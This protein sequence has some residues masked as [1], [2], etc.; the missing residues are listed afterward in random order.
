MAREAEAAMDLH[1]N[2]A[3]EKVAEH[4]RKHHQPSHAEDIYSQEESYGRNPNSP[5]A[6]YS[7]N[8]MNGGAPDPYAVQEEKELAK[9]RVQVA[10]EI[11]M[12]REAEA[13]MDLH[14]NKAAE[15]VAEHE[16]KHHQPGHAE[17]IYSQ[18]ESYGRNP[19]SPVA[20]Y[21]SNPMN[22]GA[23]D[24]YAANIDSTASTAGTAYTGGRSGG[25]PTNN[26]LL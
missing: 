7:S 22:G 5:V 10:H 14:V 15:K 25:L 20:G 16:R 19:N 18:E 12:A 13:A 23:P 17:D 2:K 11:R 21:S 1:V 6:G 24:P 26:N 8:P 3:A 4:E 9:A